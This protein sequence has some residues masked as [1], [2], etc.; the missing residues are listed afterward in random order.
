MS[1]QWCSGGVQGGGTVVVGSVIMV[2][3]S[4]TVVVGR[5]TLVHGVV[6]QWWGQWESGGGGEAVG[7]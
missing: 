7:Q 4:G 5:G 2:L 3:G 6:G 1:G